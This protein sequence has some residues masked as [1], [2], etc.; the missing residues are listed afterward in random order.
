[1]NNSRLRLPSVLAALVLL[2]V[3]S[4]SVRADE[5]AAFLRDLH[6]FRVNNFMALS[7]YYRYS[8]TNDAA[9]EA[10]IKEL[11]GEATATCRRYPKAAPTF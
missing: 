7:N 2:L 11:M 8:A 10:A 6:E 9:A 3:S 4:F 5:G 1:M